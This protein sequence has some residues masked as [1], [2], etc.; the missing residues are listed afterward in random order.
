MPAERDLN[1]CDLL[2]YTREQDAPHQ[3]AIEALVFELSEA[4]QERR[5]EDPEWWS[6][7]DAQIQSLS[8]SIDLLCELRDGAARVIRPADNAPDPT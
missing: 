1:R 6:R 8:D 3:E 7:S 4:H 5:E 2:G